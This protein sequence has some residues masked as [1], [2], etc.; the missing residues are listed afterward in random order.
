MIAR[1]IAATMALRSHGIHHSQDSEGAVVE[2]LVVK[3]DV[4][5][6][7]SRCGR[8][9]G[10]MW[11]DRSLARSLSLFANATFHLCWQPSR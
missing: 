3:D 4:E 10:P 5:G 11:L 8:A 7:K 2:R 6:S 9:D 1:S